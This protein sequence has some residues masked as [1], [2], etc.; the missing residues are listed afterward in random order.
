MEMGRQ[1][2]RQIRMGGDIAALTFVR[3]AQTEVIDDVTITEHPDL[4]SV[5]DE[6]WRGV[7]GDILRDPD[8]G[9]LYRSIHDVR[10]AGQNTQP[11]QTPSMWTRIGD[12]A[13]EWPEWAQP[14]GAHDTYPAGA[15]V[16]HNGK[17]WVNSH[18][19]GNNWAP[20]VYG[21]AEDGV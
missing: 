16:T 15:K 1:I 9:N 10:D 3:L 4:F 13:E 11:S 18:G 14:Q 6:H 12:P 7:A 2:G 20:G 5:W 8:D 21:W 19:D 17:H